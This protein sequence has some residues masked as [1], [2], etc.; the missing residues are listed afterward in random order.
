MDIRTEIQ[1]HNTE[2]ADVRECERQHT[3]N[4]VTKRAH[5]EMEVSE[6]R[7]QKRAL[8]RS[9][10]GNRILLQQQQITIN[11]NQNMITQ[12]RDIIRLQREQS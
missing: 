8:A 6:L 11:A 2:L 4:L 5:L 7:R 3:I 9:I 10:N 12:Q 1:A